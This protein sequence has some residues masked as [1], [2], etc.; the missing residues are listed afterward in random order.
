MKW[1]TTKIEPKEGDRRVKRKFAFIPTEM[2][3]GEW[4]IWLES[5]D[6]VQRYSW[7]PRPN[8]HVGIVMRHDWDEIER[9]PLWS[10]V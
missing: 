10:W 2:T 3:S 5:Y 4:T 7:G 6:S 8:H 1:K 9:V